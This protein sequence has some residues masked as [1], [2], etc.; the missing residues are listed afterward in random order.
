MKHST[1]KSTVSDEQIRANN[2]ATSVMEDEEVFYTDKE[3]D[4]CTVI[5]KGVFIVF[6]RDLLVNSVEN[7]RKQYF[8]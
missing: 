1:S 7:E 8:N 3:L 2:R 5:P 6:E 4:S